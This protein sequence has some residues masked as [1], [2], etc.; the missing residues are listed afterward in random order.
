MKRTFL[1]F[2]LALMS[3]PSLVHSQHEQIEQTPF[4]FGNNSLLRYW[5]Y[6]N[7][8]AYSEDSAASQGYFFGERGAAYPVSRVSLPSQMHVSDMEPY[9]EH[10]MFCGTQAYDNGNTLGF[11]GIMNIPNTLAW[12][13]NMCYFQFPKTNL[14]PTN[15]VFINN[16]RPTKL[17]FYT[18]T[19]ATDGYSYHALLVGECQYYSSGVISSA[20]RRTLCEAVYDSEGWKYW[21]YDNP[22]DEYEYTDVAATENYVVVVGRNRLENSMLIKVFDRHALPSIAN[23]SHQYYITELTGEGVGD[24]VLVT[25][26][27]GDRF[28]TASYYADGS[29]SG[30]SIRMFDIAAGSPQYIVGG[31]LAQST[32][33]LIPSTWE[34]R[35]L[36]YDA[37]ADRLY[38]LQRNSYPSVNL[39]FGLIQEYDVSTFATS[40]VRQY[41]DVSYNLFDITERYLGGFQTIGT[42]GTLLSSFIGLLSSDDGVSFPQIYCFLKTEKSYTIT[43]VV[44]QSV[45]I[46]EDVLQRK[47]ADSYFHVSRPYTITFDTIC[48]R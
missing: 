29:G 39:T 14:I 20:A 32:S 31:H 42:D 3:L 41:Q 40:Y 15:Q 5:F 36:R 11:L 28:A 33:T 45:I 46:D 34:L 44:G 16:F 30:T 37:V 7:R 25:P 12:G 38:L 26:L 21:F 10:L 6:A 17:A 13:Q 4:L 43:P 23:P 19:A 18:D 35:N 22:Y 48:N 24:M 1:I 27:T 8:I 47:S 2:C 9:S